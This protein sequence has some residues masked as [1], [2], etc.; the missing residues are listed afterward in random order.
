MPQSG[1]WPSSGV[2]TAASA[3]CRKPTSKPRSGRART[4]RDRAQREPQIWA[5]GGLGRG[6]QPLP[7]EPPSQALCEEIRARL[8]EL[9][10]VLE[11]GQRVLQMVT[12]EMGTAPRGGLQPRGSGS[13]VCGVPAAVP[14]RA[15]PRE[16]AGLDGGRWRCPQM[17]PC[18]AGSL[19]TWRAT[20]W[21]QGGGRERCRALPW[22]VRHQAMSQGGGSG[23]TP[24]CWVSLGCSAELPL[25]LGARHRA[26]P[27]LPRGGGT[28]IPSESSRGEPRQGSAVGWGTAAADRH[29]MGM[30]GQSQAQEEQRRG[31]AGC[32]DRRE[33]G[34]ARCSRSLALGTV[35]RC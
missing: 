3:A 17:R 23:G 5:R 33:G 10:G 21:R 22:A 30:R 34:R 35:L 31:R 27:T 4:R 19:W 12:G 32:G 6:E 7:Q 1:S 28:W 16:G 13:R 20:G 2:P 24:W 9:E 14:V 25:T 29:L 15:E 11:S 8:A 18:G 26:M